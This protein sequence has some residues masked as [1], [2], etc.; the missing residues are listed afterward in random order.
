MSQSLESRSR[1]RSCQGFGRT[2]A[3]LGLTLLCSRGRAQEGAAGIGPSLLEDPKVR[4]VLE[5]VRVNEPQ[6]LDDQVRLCEIEAPSFQEQARAAVMKAE[7]ERA[8]LRNVRLDAIGNVLG[9]RPGRLTRPRVVVASHL[10]TVFPSGTDLRVRR[11][12][13]MLKGPGIGDNCRG[14]AVLLGMVR[15]L[16]KSKIETTGPMTFVANVGEEALGNLRGAR[17]LFEV[18]L[19]GRIDRFVS[20]D[21]SGHGFVHLGVG[22]HRYKVTVKGP[23]GHSYFAFGNPN[24]VHALGRAITHIGDIQVPPDPRTT[25]S[26]G[27]INGGTS[28]NSIAFEAWMEIDMRSHDTE[29]LDAVDGQIHRA[30]ALGVQ[31]ENDRWSGKGAVTVGWESLGDRQPGITP[32]DAPIVQATIS[33]TKA[34]GLPVQPFPATTDSNIAM[35]LGVPAVTLDGGGDGSGGHSLGEVFD[36]TDSWKGTQRALLLA[37]ALARP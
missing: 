6:V 14:L 15:A 36:S 32:V 24:P 31:E 10:D 18:E 28:I 20:I 8:G 27:R 3:L 33:V 5:S 12:G 16:Q 1:A 29:A 19:L 35:A 23:G 25:F 21:G 13:A 30:V 37:L 22:V 11:E 9:E 4:E 34:L 26:V 17:H 2:L 7:F